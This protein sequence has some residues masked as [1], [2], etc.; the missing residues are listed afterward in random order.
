VKLRVF[1]ADLHIHT[2]L[3]PCAELSL[4]PRAIVRKAARQGLDVI[5]ICDHNSSENVPAVVDA[6]RDTN[7]QLK[8]LPG[9]E[10]TSKEEVHILALFDSLDRAWRL[11]EIVYERLP[12]ENDV[13][14]FGPQVVVNADHDVLGFNKRLLAGATEMSVE[15]VVDS[16][17]NLDGLAVASHVDREAFGIIAQLGFIPA[18]L[19]LDALEVSRHLSLAEVRCRFPQ[20]S[21]YTFV[22]FSDAHNLEDIGTTST[23]FLLNVATAGEIRKALRGEDGR[24]VV[25]EGG[26]VGSPPGESEVSG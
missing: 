24:R 4:G 11:Q 15:Q 14:A 21:H 2:C 19:P 9:M 16:I 23:S 3:S 10:V 13:E 25:V 18:E 8:V 20:Y 6:A 22:R 26:A 1:K 7:A 17:H 12:G 5:G